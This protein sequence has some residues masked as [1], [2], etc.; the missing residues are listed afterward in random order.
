MGGWKRYVNR[1][2]APALSLHN[3]VDRVRKND[4]LHTVRLVAVKM[5]SGQGDV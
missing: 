2:T 4:E 1:R 5:K 3:V